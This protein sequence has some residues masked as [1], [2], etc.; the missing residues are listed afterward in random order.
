MTRTFSIYEEDGSFLNHTAEP[1]AIFNAVT[2]HLHFVVD[3]SDAKEMLAYA[4]ANESYDAKNIIAIK[5]FDENGVDDQDVIHHLIERHRDG[6]PQY[7]FTVT[8]SAGK[9]INHLTEPGAIYH[10]NTGDVFVFCEDATSTDTLDHY[11]RMME[12]KRRKHPKASFKHIPN[13]TD[14][15]YVQLPKDQHTLNAICKNQKITLPAEKPSAEQPKAGAALLLRDKKGNVKD[16][17]KQPAIIFNRETGTILHIGEAPLIQIE[18]AIKQGNLE[19]AGYTNRAN[20]LVYFE[21]PHEQTELDKVHLVPGYA[22]VLYAKHHS[23]T[24]S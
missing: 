5:L 9:S 13:L 18:F 16:R 15:L 12:D 11:R 19:V 7:L 6:R 1:V 17:L 20:H 14:I 22:P 10:A 21:L 8:D 23:S 3:I 2:G 24:R 4:H